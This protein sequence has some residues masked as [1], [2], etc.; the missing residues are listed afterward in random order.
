[1]EAVMHDMI[2]LSFEDAE[3]RVMT[4]EA[5]EP[6]FV[7]ADVCR[8]LEVGNP[9]DAATRL[10]EDERMTLDNAEGHSGQRGGA[11]CFN[12]VNEAGLY[13][14]I[15][16][17]RKPAAERFKRWLAHDVLPTLRKTG[18]FHMEAPAAPAPA[19][20]NDEALADLEERRQAVNEISL[21]LRVLGRRAA[22]QLWRSNGL[23]P[24]PS[25]D[26]PPHLDLGISATVIAFA[27]EQVEDAP[28]ESLPARAAYG[29]YCRWCVATRRQPVTE[30]RF[31]RDLARMGYRKTKRQTVY[32]EDVRLLG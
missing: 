32:Y 24:Q 30:T 10:D 19:P 21:A 9:S 15:F 5:G 6:W 8:V 12:V 17:S 16:T 25:Q 20:A 23:L 26:E 22:R 18:R 28:G 13:R 27:D 11:R 31:G 1:M 14:L 2:P 29:A 4:D 3:V 7:L